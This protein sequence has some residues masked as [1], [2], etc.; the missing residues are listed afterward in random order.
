MSFNHYW[1]SKRHKD[2]WEKQGPHQGPPEAASSSQQ[3]G[4]IVLLT[5]G[6]DSEFFLKLLSCMVLGIDSMALHTLGKYSTTTLYSLPRPSLYLLYLMASLFVCLSV[7][8]WGLSLAVHA[9]LELTLS[10]RQTLNLQTPCLGL[11]RRQTT[12]L[13]HL[14]TENTFLNI[15][16]RQTIPVKRE[17]CSSC[18]IGNDQWSIGGWKTI[19]GSIRSE[20]TD[21]Y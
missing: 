8:R 9:G 7:L 18:F 10:S 1:Q 12:D 6:T 14:F 21:E 3:S 19:S 11:Q 20:K 16:N 5:E 4:T 13:S 15:K 17:L 2:T